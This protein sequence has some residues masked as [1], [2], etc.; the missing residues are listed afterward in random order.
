MNLQD[1]HLKSQTPLTGKSSSE[2]TQ[3]VPLCFSDTVTV[4]FKSFVN[5]SPVLFYYALIVYYKIA[6]IISII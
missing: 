1:I 2:N 3:S 5:S 4:L 6:V